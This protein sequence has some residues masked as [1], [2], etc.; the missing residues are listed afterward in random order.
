MTY[1]ENTFANY[2]TKV[3]PPKCRGKKKLKGKKMS[4]DMERIHPR[5]NSHGSYS[6][7]NMINFSHSKNI[8]I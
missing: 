3:Q 2:I 7:D 5:R 4:G 8:V 1:W 6:F